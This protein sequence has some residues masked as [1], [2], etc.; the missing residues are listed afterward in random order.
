MPMTTAGT[1]T[2]KTRRM[3]QLTASA[4]VFAVTC[5]LAANLAEAQTA[6]SIQKPPTAHQIE[7]MVAPV[8]RVAPKT[9]VAPQALPLP[10]SAAGLVS[11]APAAAAKAPAAKPAPAVVAAA[12]AASAAPVAARSAAAKPAAAPKYAVYTCKVGQDYSEK[13]KAC[14]TPGVSKVASAVGSAAKSL[15][16]KVSGAADS[17]V[18]SSLGFRAKP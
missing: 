11:A 7:P 2:I 8:R 18:R 13:L 1:I 15:R 16:G 10:A 12:P 9:V 4:S 6:V 5:V 3:A 17:S 14:F